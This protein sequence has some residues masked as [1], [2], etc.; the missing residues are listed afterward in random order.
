MLASAFS[1]NYFFAIS[2]EQVFSLLEK[3]FPSEAL[4]GKTTINSYCCV[5]QQP[6][7]S[8]IFY[9]LTVERFSTQSMTSIFN[10]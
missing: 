5:E 3:P 1:H 9:R 2:Y 4:T 8:L 6:A 7:L 10:N